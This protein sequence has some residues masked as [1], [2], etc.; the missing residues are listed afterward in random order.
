MALFRLFGLFRVF[1][2]VGGLHTNTC[3]Q[4][5]MLSEEVALGSREPEAGLGS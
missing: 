4:F 3:W 5:G 1:L 2:A